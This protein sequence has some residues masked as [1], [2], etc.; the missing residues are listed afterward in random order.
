MCRSVTVTSPRAIQHSPSAWAGFVPKMTTMLTVT[1]KNP[2]IIS[3]CILRRMLTNPLEYVDAIAQH[4][5][6]MQILP[7]V[8]VACHD[9]LERSV[10]DSA[11]FSANET[12]L[13]DHL[14]AT[15][16]FGAYS[17]DVSV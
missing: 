2:C 17:D 10:V 16:T 9:A 1:E 14:R 3:R 11:S 4:D 5:S 13:E 15:E 7:G 6:S 12:L 8:S